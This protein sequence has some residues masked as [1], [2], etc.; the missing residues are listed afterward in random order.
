MLPRNSARSRSKMNPDRPSKNLM[1]TLPRTASQTT[2][3]ATWSVR[4]L[5]STLPMKLRSVSSSSSVARWIRASPL[6]FSSPIDRSATRGRSTPSTRS[7]KIAPMRAYWARFSAVESGFAPMS[8]STNGL[9]P[10]TIWTAS[11]GRSTPRRRPSR[12]TA[13]AIPAPVWPAVT[14]ASASPF[15]TRSVATRIEASFFSRRASAGCSCMPTTSAA[16]TVRTFAGRSRSR[17]ARTA[18]GPTRMTV[19]SGWARAYAREPGT[20]SAAP[21][22]PPTASTATRTPPRIGAVVAGR[23][24]GVTTRLRGLL[25]RGRSAGR[26]QLDRLAAVVPPA[27]RADPV[28][29][30]RLVAMRAFDE[31]RQ[32][33]GEVAPALHLPR[34]SDLSLRHTHVGPGSL[35]AGDAGAPA[36]RSGDEDLALRARLRAGRRG[37]GRCG[38]L[39]ALVVSVEPEGPE[40]L[41]PRVDRAVLVRVAGL[42][43]LAALG[44]EARGSPA[45]TAGRSAPAG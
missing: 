31:L 35:L 8:S 19:S 24:G 20:T 1:T 17:G 23:S 3:S 36:G 5:P 26:L 39:P 10:P 44:A 33:E 28:R 18:S 12:R 40:R 41:Q 43:A 22:S 16:W 32:G 30:L 2:T 38:S 42:E 13:A 14:T 7:E 34:V 27:R 6:P 37:E 45:R 4:S 15:R 9:S 11:A 29:E 21:W 25:A